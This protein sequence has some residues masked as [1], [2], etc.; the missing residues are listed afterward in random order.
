MLA[1]HCKLLFPVCALLASLRLFYWTE[2][3]AMFSNFVK[4][5]LSKCGKPKLRMF[6]SCTNVYAGNFVDCKDDRASDR[7]LKQK[8]DTQA[9][10]VQQGTLQPAEQKSLSSSTKAAQAKDLLTKKLY[11]GESLEVDLTTWLRHTFPRRE[12][13]AITKGIVNDIKD[14][15]RMNSTSMKIDAVAGY[16]RSSLFQNWD[17][18]AK[19]VDVNISG[20]LRE[21]ALGLDEWSRS[22]KTRQIP[23]GRECVARRRDAMHRKVLEILREVLTKH[24]RF[25]GG[26]RS[27]SSFG[28]HKA[29]VRTRSDVTNE[30]IIVHLY[31]NNASIERQTHITAECGRSCEHGAEFAFFVRRWAECRGMIASI[32]KGHL[33]T[34]AWTVLALYF[35]QKQR[36][37]VMTSNTG[38]SSV[39]LL[40]FQGFLT[41]YSQRLTQK[42]DVIFVDVPGA[43]QRDASA[44]GIR[45]NVFPFIEDP[46]E[47]SIDLGAFMTTQASARMW[48]DIS[49]TLHV[50]GDREKKVTL[51][52][53]LAENE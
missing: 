42:D 10:S 26:A 27:I 20:D 31:I 9:A 32:S 44:A 33:T 52:E 6:T 5:P 35:L 2:V 39:V 29:S 12:S 13:D 37:N 53:F 17:C 7:H 28:P 48:G 4:K 23:R 30:E 15:V 45:F 8:R 46:F 50:L 14:A 16:A 41:F 40:L 11:P 43:V 3:R 34:Y 38:P 21:I 51:V 25:F 18:S 36:S 22:V 49:R 47:P 1:S 19:E 24:P